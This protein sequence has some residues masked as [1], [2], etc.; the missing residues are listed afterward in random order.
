MSLPAGASPTDWEEAAT[1]ADVDWVRTSAATVQIS[2]LGMQWELTCACRGTPRSVRVNEPRSAAERLDVA[3]MARAIGRDLRANTPPIR[4]APPPPVRLVPPVQNAPRP[5]PTRLS[6]PPR[7]EMS[8]ARPPLETVRQPLPALPIAPPRPVLP[9][10]QP[11]ERS[12]TLPHLWVGLGIGLRP[13]TNPSLRMSG[14]VTILTGRHLSMGVSGTAITSRSL[15]GFNK[16][17]WHNRKMW[18]AG[19]HILGAVQVGEWMQFDAGIG[20]TRQ[21]YHQNDRPLLAVTVPQ[22]T[23]DI[24]LRAPGDRRIGLRV[25]GTADLRGVALVDELTAQQQW[26]VP[27]EFRASIVARIGH[28][29]DPSNAART[30]T[31]HW[32][33]STA[34]FDSED[35][36]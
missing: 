36:P 17:P 7:V 14:G 31:E 29:A 21:A 6:A 25:G 8:V 18:E 23:V 26:L 9:D 34:V 20:A 35:L 19:A 15:S 27:F 16:R 12:L 1:V 10:F 4:L 5:I 32:P 24:E 28:R 3:V 13:E 11:A 2:D 33:N 30:P 22:L